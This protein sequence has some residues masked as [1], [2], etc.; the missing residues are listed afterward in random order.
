MARNT[1][2]KGFSLKDELFNKKKVEYLGC[3]FAEVETSFNTKLFVE[4]VMKSLLSLELKQRIVCITKSLEQQLPKDF[5]KACLIITKALP[6][7]LDPTNTD[8]DFG[9]FIFA[10]LGEYV[11]R[12]GMKKELLDTSFATLK[13]ITKRFSMEDAIR[14]FINAFPEE[15]MQEFALWVHDDHYH[16]R[17]LVSEGTR[18]MLPWSGRINVE[19]LAPIP[20]LDILHADST[21]YVTRSVANHMNDIAKIKPDLVVTTLKQWKKEKK[22]GEKE[23]DWMI[24]HSLRTLVKQGNKGALELL[25]YNTDPKIIVSTIAVKSGDIKLGESLEFSFSIIA[26]RD[27]KLMI[28]YVID[29]VKANG[30]TKPKVFKLKKVFMYKGETISVTKKHRF[31]AD[32]TTFK[33]YAGKHTV[34][35]QING[36]QQAVVPFKLK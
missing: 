4:D 32:A 7:E 31:L 26:Q 18:P 34:K 28:D 17:R 2:G 6:P 25:G 10:P 12:N 11:V 1:N 19:I 9:D 30:E 14:Y 29:F 13:E 15:T 33:H 27:E 35:L 21:R 20:Y 8:D 24:R 36:N 16:V 3:L 22:Q 23:L 5:K